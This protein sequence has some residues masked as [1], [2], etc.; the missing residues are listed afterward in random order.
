LLKTGDLGR[1]LSNGALGDRHFSA[2]DILL[3]GQLL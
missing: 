3:L 2:R 1:K